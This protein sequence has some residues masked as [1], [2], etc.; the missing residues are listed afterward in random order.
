MSFSFALK[1]KGNSFE[2]PVE[3]HFFK[4][5]NCDSGTLNV[6]PR[7]ISPVVRPSLSHFIRWSLEPWVNDS[8]LKP[9]VA[10]FW[11]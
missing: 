1:Q 4:F 6:F 3:C 7:L 5:Y 11:R 10:F 2:L 8:G 9:P